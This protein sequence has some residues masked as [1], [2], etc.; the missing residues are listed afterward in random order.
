MA[1]HDI[2]ARSITVGNMFKLIEQ[3]RQDMVRG[4][5]CFVTEQEAGNLHSRD[6]LYLLSELSDQ[7]KENSTANLKRPDS[8][9]LTSHHLRSYFQRERFHPKERYLHL[10]S[11]LA[12]KLVLTYE[13]STS[14]QELEGYLDCNNIAKHNRT[15]QETIAIEQ[16]F[17]DHTEFLLG[18]MCCLIWCI[19]SRSSPPIQIESCPMWIDILFN[20]QNAI[21]I[22]EELKRAER[23]YLYARY[24]L[25][26]ATATVLTRAWCLFEIMTRLKSERMKASILHNWSK[27]PT[28]FV[29]VSSVFDEMQ[30]S[31]EEDKTLIQSKILSKFGD[32]HRFGAAVQRIIKDSSND[33]A[34]LGSVVGQF[35]CLYFCGFCLLSLHHAR[36]LF[37]QLVSL[38]LFTQ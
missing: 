13:W 35:L 28:R 15:L 38:L 14:F 33:K 7:V 10:F 34:N 11:P 17:E 37:L 20:D 26:I 1:S 25:V 16:E 5:Y 31:Y 36:F 32:K 8:M 3:V 2:S 22:Q 21:N 30:A 6:N 24:H 23:I 18:F 27:G 29:H 12:P 4:G 9:E 19:P